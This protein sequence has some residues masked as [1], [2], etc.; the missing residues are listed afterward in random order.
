MTSI[1]PKSTQAV[2][3]V[4]A[5]WFVCACGCRS[6]PSGLPNPFLAP[7]LVPPPATR[8]LLPGQAQPYYPGDPLPVMQSSNPP[9]GAPSSANDQLAAAQFAGSD[10]LNWNEPGG[11]SAVVDDVG[12]TRALARSNESAVAIPSD[13]DS[14]RF[15]LPASEA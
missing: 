3:F 12:P 14:L 4:A 8:A 1:H 15:A 10:G 13:G 5:S 11:G 6:Q 7:D 2:A 9:A